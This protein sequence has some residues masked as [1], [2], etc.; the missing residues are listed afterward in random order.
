MLYTN[1]PRTDNGQWRRRERLLDWQEQQARQIQVV[2]FVPRSVGFIESYLY[3]LR[4]ELSGSGAMSSAT[5][6][7]LLSSLPLWRILLDVSGADAQLRADIRGLLCRVLSEGSVRMRSI[8]RSLARELLELPYFAEN[9][10]RLARDI[11][12][13]VTERLVELN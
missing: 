7:Q 4:A 8:A 13:L 12:D 5:L 9:R 6:S 3:Q 11:Q 1:K 2:R 10:G